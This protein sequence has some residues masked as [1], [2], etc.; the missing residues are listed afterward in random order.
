MTVGAN[1][2]AGA[3]N[4][5]TDGTDA[6]RSAE[7]VELNWLTS[8]GSRLQPE[9]SALRGVAMGAL[10]ELGR[11]ILM[12]QALKTKAPPV[13]EADNVSNGQPDAEAVP[14]R[15]AAARRRKRDFSAPA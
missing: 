7:A 1:P 3:A 10:L 8:L 2:G 4:E 13:V 9:I 12:K 14:A 11:G 6:A 15:T 5:C